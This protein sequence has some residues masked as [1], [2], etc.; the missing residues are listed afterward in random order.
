[1]LGMGPGGEDPQA[2]VTGFVFSM[3]HTSDPDQ[4][5]LA[6]SILGPLVK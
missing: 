6:G 4:I 2:G 5:R 1:V 3:P